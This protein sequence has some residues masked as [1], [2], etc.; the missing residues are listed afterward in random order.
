M[1]VCVCVKT[2]TSA[3]VTRDLDSAGLLPGPSRVTM[4]T[5]TTAVTVSQDSTSR[6]G[7]VPVRRLSA[8]QH[9][10]TVLQSHAAS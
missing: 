10:F 2:S 7:L 5:E 3:P 9:R 1:C 8:S 6:T 4:A